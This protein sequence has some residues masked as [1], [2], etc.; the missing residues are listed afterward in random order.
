MKVAITG[1]TSGIGLAIA[2]AF[3]ARGDE[4][5]GMSRSNGYDLAKKRSKV[6]KVASKCDVFVNNRHQYNDDTQ[7]QLLFA[8]AEAWDGQDKTIVN[9]GSR[10]GEWYLHGQSD[11]YSVYKHA[12]DAAC[13]Q[14]FNRPDQRPR[15]M[16]VRPGWV[17][18][19]SVR[20]VR[21][22]KLSP[23]DV[24]R[25]VMWMIDQPRHVLISSVTLSHHVTGGR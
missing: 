16:N 5:V 7:L 23:Q 22:P 21:A 15:V 11:A 8:M 1:H 12:L 24:A 20:R 17:D 25:V 18:T 4:V 2:D 9:L 6:V 19:D 13:Q 10:A 14:L 3:R